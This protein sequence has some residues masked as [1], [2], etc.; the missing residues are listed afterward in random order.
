MVFHVN[1][2]DPMRDLSRRHQQRR[3][4]PGERSPSPE[5]DRT[6]ILLRIFGSPD[7]KQIDGLGG[8]TMQTSKAMVVG[9]SAAPNA[10]IQMTFAQVSL[11]DA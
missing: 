10:D 8:A 4:V 5:E 6:R 2:N 9:P 11:K 7:P 1:R 3:D